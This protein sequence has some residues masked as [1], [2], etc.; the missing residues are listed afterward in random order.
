[1]SSHS[2]RTDCG[3]GCKITM[4]ET[5]FGLWRAKDEKWVSL[6]GRGTL[7]SPHVGVCRAV[8]NNVR[9]DHDRAI[10][11]GFWLFWPGTDEE[12]SERNRRWY[13]E[14]WESM[15]LAVYELGEDGLP[16]GLPLTDG[17]LST[18]KE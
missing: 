16:T 8:Y 4:S 3:Q 5:L 7:F 2:Q 13:R 1:M 17:K 10:E 15:W 9:N 12:K 11:Q 6:D 18:T 14:H